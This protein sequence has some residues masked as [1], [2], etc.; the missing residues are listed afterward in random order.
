MRTLHA[1]EFGFRKSSD[2]TAVQLGEKGLCHQRFKSRT[3]SGAKPLRGS[4]STSTITARSRTIPRSSNTQKSPWLWVESGPGPRHRGPHPDGSRPEA[5][6]CLNQDG[7][8]QTG[9]S[10]DTH[11][12]QSSVSKPGRHLTELHLFIVT[13]LY[14]TIKCL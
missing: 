12:S 13:F 6:A 1:L 5:A 2:S 7:P 11:I 8:G 3:G 9:I 4:Y 14:S 10:L